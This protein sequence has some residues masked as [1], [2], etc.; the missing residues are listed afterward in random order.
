MDNIVSDIG[1]NFINAAA[2]TFGK[3]VKRKPFNKHKNYKSWYN[4]KC[5]K[6]RKKFHKAPEKYNILQNPNNR[7]PMKPASKEHKATFN[8]AIADF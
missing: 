6:S 5:A 1:K 7:F 4:I 3:V 8:K 2:E